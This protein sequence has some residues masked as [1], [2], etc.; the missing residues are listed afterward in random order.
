MSNPVAEVISAFTSPATYL[1]DIISKGI[2]VL[3]EPHRIKKEADAVAYKINKISQVISDNGNESIEYNDN[4]L[5][6]NN[7]GSQFYNNTIARF[8]HLELQREINIEKI[9]DKAYDILLEKTQQLKETVSQDWMFKFIT[10]AQDVSEET[11]QTLWAKILANEILKPNSFSLRTLNVLKNMSKNDALLFEKIC[12]C[13]INND[14]VPNEL[15]ILKK[16][17]ITYKDI[18]S[19]DEY[20]LVN[21]SGTAVTNFNITTT[22]KMLFKNDLWVCAANNPSKISLLCFPLTNVA[23]EIKSIINIDINEKFLLE[24]AQKISDD[25]PKSQIVLY[26]K[27]VETKYQ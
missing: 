26:K 4:N 13:I 3:Y 9:A 22:N 17:G 24:Y 16:Y 23:K 25:N 6:I 7:Y 19:L 2:G 5:I 20:G 27:D 1:I 8:V 15:L 10:S 12:S 11:I 21:S 14:F 18:V